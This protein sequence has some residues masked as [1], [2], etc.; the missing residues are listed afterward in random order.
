MDRS[1]TCT[2]D[3]NSPTDWLKTFG[4]KWDSISKMSQNAFQKLTLNGAKQE[5]DESNNGS[6]MHFCSGFLKGKF[7]E[8]LLMSDALGT[9]LLYRSF[10]SIS[11]G[12]NLAVDFLLILRHHVR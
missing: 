2:E 5:D 3:R 10:G 12:E 4:K 1:P 9:G 6:E 8:N 11:C 7:L